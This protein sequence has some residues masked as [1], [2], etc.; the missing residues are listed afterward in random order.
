VPE[1]SPEPLSEADLIEWMNL[2]DMR[3]VVLQAG[4]VPAGTHPWVW[5]LTRGIHNPEHGSAE[6]ASLAFDAAY[7]ALRRLAISPGE[8]AVVALERQDRE[9][10]A[11]S[12]HGGYAHGGFAHQGNLVIADEVQGLAAWEQELLAPTIQAPQIQPQQVSYGWT[13][14]SVSAAGANIP[15]Y[16]TPRPEYTIEQLRNR[17]RGRS[18]W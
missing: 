5:R 12:A 1:N 6:T 2:R 16:P 10:R 14:S 11:Q 3:I 17:L 8:R 13:T 18:T 7:S 4:P 9:R 15:A